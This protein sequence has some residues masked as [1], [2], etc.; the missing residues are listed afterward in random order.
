M[1]LVEDLVG[2]MPLPSSL[3]YL[4]WED[5]ARAY[6]REVRCPRL[7]DTVYYID[8]AGS[9]AA[10]GLTTGT[11]WQ[12]W[13]RVQTFIAGWSQVAG[14]VTFLFKRG[15][16]WDYAGG[17]DTLG[18]DFM[19]FSDYGTGAY[20]LL[21]A[22][23]NKFAS[24]GSL[25]TLA[26]GA[27]Y[28][29]TVA[30]IGTIRRQTQRKREFTKVASTAEVEATPNSWFWSGNTLHLHI[31]GPAGT[32]VDPDTI[33]LEYTLA[34][35]TSVS[36][37]KIDAASDGIHVSNLRFDGQGYTG[38]ADGLQSYGVSSAVNGTNVA[39]I[40]NVQAYFHNRH[41]LG[42]NGGGSGSNVGG[43]SVFE[44][45]ELGK[46]WESAAIPLIHYAG[47]GDHEGIYYN[48]TIENG[49]VRENATRN[50]PTGV[51]FYCHSNAGVGTVGFISIRNLKCPKPK[52][53][54][55]VAGTATFSN[56][57][58]QTTLAA[59]RVVEIGSIYEAGQYG[60]GDG[61][62]PWGANVYYANRKLHFWSRNTGSNESMCTVASADNPNAGGW[63]RNSVIDLDLSDIPTA[64]GYFAIYNPTVS[65]LSFPD[66][67][68]VHIRIYNP[69]RLNFC[70]NYDQL[71]ANGTTTTN[72]AGTTVKNS[73][74]QYL[75]DDTVEANTMRLGMVDSAI[76][77]QNNAYIGLD[78]GVGLNLNGHAN[79]VNP[80]Y[81]GGY[82]QL[83]ADPTAFDEL[84]G[85]AIGGLCEYDH[86]LS[87]RNY[88]AP[89]IGPFEVYDPSQYYPSL[90]ELQAAQAEG[91]AD[92]INDAVL[93]GLASINATVRNEINETRY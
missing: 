38:F 1:S 44:N 21:N 16:V 91:I 59:C 51:G 48:C 5:S 13:A 58:P 77:L 34:A 81:L 92:L 84:A 18:K 79:T 9:D 4:R 82:M 90:A 25:W 7:R 65:L 74:V 57:K 55:G 46:C 10:N 67:G 22:F 28:T 63:D 3:E 52:D 2:P 35:T 45:C 86:N 93:A 15:G 41:N 78:A 61:F 29:T 6:V 87:P 85:K 50:Y 71:F 47:G 66:L 17:L 53:G 76:A 64:R 32:A 80:V 42:H 33:A 68:H 8:P 24:G 83:W 27:R 39:Y 23:V 30:S 26:S 31:I 54:Y 40:G 11:A 14:G 89:T 36:G 20:P 69:N 37:I 70:I 88:V 43:L 60:G 49:T 19:S 12:T 72:A 62:L 73:I 56:V 75:R